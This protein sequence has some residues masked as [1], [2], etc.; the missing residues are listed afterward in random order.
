[1]QLLAQHGYGNGNKVQRGLDDGLI[2]GVIFGAKDIAPQ[3][4]AESLEQ[5]QES[6][7]ECVRLF[8]PQYYA[9]LLAAQ[10]GARLG[11]L[12]GQDSYTYFQ[13]RRRRDLEREGQV[14]DDLRTVLDFQCRL[15]VS[16]LIA[17]NIVIRRSFDS[18]EATVAKTFLR[19]AASS[20]S[21]LGDVRPLYATLAISSA[22]LADRIELQ[23][24][25]QEVTEI[26]DPPT[27][28]YLLLERPDNSITSALT[29]PDLLSRWMLVNHVLKLTGFQ[30]INGYTDVLSPYL[31]A[32]G[33]DAVA[34]GWFNTLKCFSLKKFE[35]VSDFARRPVTRY[36]SKALLKS[37]RSTELHDLRGPFPDVLNGL[38]TDDAYDP[39]EG[40]TPDGISEVLQNWDG[41]RMMNELVVEGDFTAS[42]DACRGALDVAEEL[43]VRIREFGLTMR[44]RSGAAHVEL[45]REELSAFE[46][47]AEL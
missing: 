33:A 41:I 35:P 42:L 7:P 37:I 25:L 31:G 43:Y 10:P 30:V 18:L 15:P 47:L 13:A 44:D 9:T 26:E 22:A 20:V 3:K 8:D 2:D 6:H 39:E 28:F 32:A 19:N 4:L 29:E 1:M 36:L 38:P 14:L 23:N 11:W 16:A 24:F 46:A 40:S 5:V 17:P 34:A 27:G 45:I 21:E 12:F